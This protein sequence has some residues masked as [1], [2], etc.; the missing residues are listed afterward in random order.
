M[1]VASLGALLLVVTIAVIVRS[2]AY[3]LVWRAP[4]GYAYFP[5]SGD[6]FLYKYDDQVSIRETKTGSLRLA[7]EPWDEGRRG[8]AHLSPLGR[9]VLLADEPNYGTKREEA[10]HL[11][12]ALWDP[13]TGRLVR[14]FDVGVKPAGQSA[15]LWAFM[16]PDESRL[17]VCVG[18]WD[19]NE[20][21]GRTM[22]WTVETGALLFVVDGKSS[23]SLLSIDGSRLATI[24]TG[25][26]TYA[27]EGDVAEVRNA[28]TGEVISRLEPK[29]GIERIRWARDRL[30]MLVTDRTGKRIVFDTDHGHAVEADHDGGGSR[31]AWL[32]DGRSD[33]APDGI[34]IA[35]VGR[36]DGFTIDIWDARS[37]SRLT[38]FGVGDDP[39]GPAMLL[40][41]L[42]GLR[43]ID[44]Y[45]DNPHEPYY[46]RYS[47]DG[48][49][50]IAWCDGKVKLYRRRRPEWWW[51]HLYRVEV[52]MWFIAGV[53]FTANVV[54]C[55]RRRQVIERG[56]ADES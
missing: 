41:W 2:A 15:S 39:S 4:G 8:F 27:L 22:A 45:S 5:P 11:S 24:D 14:E 23:D 47:P 19:E 16:S 35:H 34:R 36:D 3:E 21:F 28:L 9:Y 12:A 51:G 1:R 38:S 46:P 49:H 29:D 40:L 42:L 33:K 48:E 54:V 53:L 26:P 56:A 6:F 50:I 17:Y 30:Q 31:L 52:W 55:L 18:F 13:H 37:R 7:I 43:Q 10:S 25:A 20:D 44:D 32:P